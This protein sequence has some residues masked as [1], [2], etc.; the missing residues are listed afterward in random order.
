[1]KKLLLLVS[2]ILSSSCTTT[3]VSGNKAFLLTSAATEN[4]QGDEAYK[5]ILKKEKEVT[6]SAQSKMV[7]EIG[8]RIAAVANEPD[9]KWEFKTLQSDEPNAFCLPGGKVA[10]YTGIFKY[11]ENE[12]GLATVMGHEIGHAIARHGGQR[13]TQQMIAA[14]ASTAVAAAI[15]LSK[16]DDTKKTLAMA[17][18]GAGVTY[19]VI[20]PFSRSDETEADEIG[21]VL[22]SKAGYNPNEAVAFWDRFS[23]ASGSAPPQFMSTH[24]NSENRREHL[25]ALVPKVMNDYNSSARLGSGKNI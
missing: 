6:G 23:K 18:F 14:G 8:R 10:V 3:P 22:M 9:F 5:E 20:L 7:E 15:G 17:A 2:V 19:G 12:A 24:P 11:A 4:Q 13:M 25:K 16:L 1:M 21:L